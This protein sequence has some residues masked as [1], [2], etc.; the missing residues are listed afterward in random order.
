MVDLGFGLSG[1]ISAGLQN[2]SVTNKREQEHEAF[3]IRLAPNATAMVFVGAVAPDAPPD[4]LPVKLWVVS[5]PS[6]QGVAVHSTSM[7]LLATMRSYVSWKA[8]TP[9]RPTS[10]WAC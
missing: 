10:H 8:P 6:P 4:R 7:S 3:L 1:A 5:S 2:I 9:E